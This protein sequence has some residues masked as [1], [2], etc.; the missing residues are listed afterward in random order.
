MYKLQKAHTGL[1][2]DLAS[3]STLLLVPGKWLLF[4][5]SSSHICREPREA[6]TIS[7]DTICGTHKAS[8]FSGMY[9]GF[10]RTTGP[11]GPRN[12]QIIHVAV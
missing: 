1:S 11:Q 7:G 9:S 8:G 2:V 6:D 3:P 5:G 4:P 12:R 10:A